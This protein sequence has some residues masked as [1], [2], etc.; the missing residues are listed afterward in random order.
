MKH[1]LN[2]IAWNW[3]ASAAIAAPMHRFI[4]EAG[5]PEGLPDE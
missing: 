3:C 2:M 5:P 1:V 4:P